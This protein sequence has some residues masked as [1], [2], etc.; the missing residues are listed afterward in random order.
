[1]NRKN[2]NRNYGKQAL[3]S[4]FAIVIGLSVVVETMIC[5]NGPEWL[6]PVLL[7]MPAMATTVANRVSFREVG[8]T[9]WFPRYMRDWE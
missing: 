6:Y 8:G 2:E 7:W 4:L 1:M 5:R 3:L 9:S